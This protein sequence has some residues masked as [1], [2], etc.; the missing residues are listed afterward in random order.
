[1]AGIQEIE[2]APAIPTEIACAQLCGL[3]HFRMRGYLRVATDSQYES[4]YA[5]EEALLEDVDEGY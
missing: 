3:G 4:W 1:M 5:N 2:A